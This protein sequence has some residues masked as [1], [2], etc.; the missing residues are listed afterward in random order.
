MLLIF[1]AR[2]FIY[3]NKFIASNNKKSFFIIK[4]VLLT[5][6]Y[7]LFSLACVK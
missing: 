1:E 5:Y 2:F 4:I 6:L 7:F 3:N